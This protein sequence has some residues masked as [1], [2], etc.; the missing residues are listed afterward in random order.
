[1]RSSGVNG[2]ARAVSVALSWLVFGSLSAVA[3][4]EQ[5]ATALYLDR[6]VAIERTLDDPTDLWVSPA[7][8]TELNGFVLKPEGAC[9]DE[10]CIPVD[11]GPESEIVTRRGEETWFSL[12]GFARRVGQSFVADTEAR[13]WSFAPVPAARSSF[14]DQAYA[15]DF[16]LPDRQGDPV[17]LSDFRGK[18]V[19]IITWASW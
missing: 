1:M 12:T 19:L 7:Q 13:V 3:A 6:T 5:S 15:P 4:A 10:L 18:K 14:V 9:L 8:L 17:R 11:Q 16:V 2:P